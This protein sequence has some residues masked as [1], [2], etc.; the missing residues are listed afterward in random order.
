[1]WLYPVPTL[2]A[3]AGWLFLFATSGAQVI[4]FGLATLALGVL[5]FLVWAKGTGQWPWV[6][7]GVEVTN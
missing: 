3:L 7:R 1:M 5:V 4:F 2:I 6:G